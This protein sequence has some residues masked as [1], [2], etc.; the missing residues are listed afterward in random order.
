MDIKKASVPLKILMVIAA[1]ALAAA[2]LWCLGFLLD[3]IQNAWGLILDVW[4]GFGKT[5]PAEYRIWSYAGGLGL[6]LLAGILFSP[7]MDR[8]DLLPQPRL[9]TP[10]KIIFVVVSITIFAG[11]A[12]L[13]LGSLPDKFDLWGLVQ[14]AGLFIAFSLSVHLWCRK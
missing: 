1:L 2:A 3:N 4:G 11:S 9:I 13:A 5:L 6:M 7:V 8:L 12:L 14:L 10:I